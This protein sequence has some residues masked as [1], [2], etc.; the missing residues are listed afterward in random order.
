MTRPLQERYDAIVVG[1]GFGGGMA[2]HVL[3][4]AGCRVLMIERGDWVARGPENWLP[5]NVGP[6]GPYYSSAPPYQQIARRGWQSVGAFHCVGGPS[7]F[8]GGVS[9][10]FREADF[11]PDPGVVAA[12]GARWPFGY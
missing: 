10:R 8:Y 11:D 9:L 1:S 6:L 12:S 7:V 5:D 3:I 4:E 2:A